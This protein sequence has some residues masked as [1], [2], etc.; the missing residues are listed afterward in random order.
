MFVL[1]DI[2]ART[3]QIE[4]LRELFGALGYEAFWEPVPVQAWLGEAAGVARVALVARHGAFRIFALEATSPEDAAR[5]AA[6]RLSAGAS[7]RG[8][9]PS[10]SSRFFHR[11][12]WRTRLRS[13]SG[14]PGKSESNRLPAPMATWTGVINWRHSQHRLA[15]PL[16]ARARPFRETDLAPF[17]SCVSQSSSSR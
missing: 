12:Y 16:Q 4:S 11:P 9:T 7:A 8:T 2:L 15:L 5:A 1:R 13:R 14:W 10:P 3:T 6:R 17:S